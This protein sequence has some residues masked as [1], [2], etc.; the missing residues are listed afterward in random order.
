MYVTDLATHDE[1]TKRVVNEQTNSKEK[2][3]SFSAFSLKLARMLKNSTHGLPAIVLRTCPSDS[4]IPFIF[5]PEPAATRWRGRLTH[6]TTPRGTDRSPPTRRRPDR[7]TRARCRAVPPCSSGQIPRL[8]PRRFPLP[9]PP[10]SPNPQSRNLAAENPQI[11]PL[12][13]AHSHSRSSRAIR[14]LPFPAHPPA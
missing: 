6:P 8:L 3:T 11:K 4:M 13:P 2:Q 5:F 7:R 9:P 10:P 12:A 14:S 1:T